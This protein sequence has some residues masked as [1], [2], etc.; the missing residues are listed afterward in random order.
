MGMTYRNV[1]NACA[2]WRKIKYEDDFVPR[3]NLDS[4]LEWIPELYT[5]LQDA[6]ILLEKIKDK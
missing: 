1:E 4:I 6:E 5:T 3:D 2:T